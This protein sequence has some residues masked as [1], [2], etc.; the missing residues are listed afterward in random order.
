MRGVGV[1]EPGLAGSSDGRPAPIRV[2]IESPR[3]GRGGHHLSDRGDLK[4]WVMGASWERGDW[5]G[6]VV[7]WCSR[8]ADETSAFP[9]AARAS[10]NASPNDFL[11]A[12][13]PDVEK[14][15]RVRLG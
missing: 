4:V 10:P 6:V 2:E 11:E 3:W 8:A 12:E 1:V 5:N 13:S 15:L 7:R 9:G 14:R